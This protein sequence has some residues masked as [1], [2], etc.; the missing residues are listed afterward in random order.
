M[1]HSKNT[2]VPQSE[3]GHF[4]N[5]TKIPF[6]FFLVSMNK[7]MNYQSDDRRHVADSVQEIF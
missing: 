5:Y 7:S 2:S 4:Y 1:S 3:C 6:F